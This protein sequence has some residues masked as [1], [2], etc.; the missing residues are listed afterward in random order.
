MVTVYFEVWSRSFYRGWG[1]LTS[2]R[3]S[4]CR[5]S[6]ITLCFNWW[7]NKVHKGPWSQLILRCDL[8]HFLGGGEAWPVRDFSYCRINNITLCFNWRVNKVHKGPWPGSLVTVYFEVWSRTCII[9]THDCV[10]FTIDITAWIN[11][12]IFLQNDI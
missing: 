2:K 6:N 5:I 12:H 1:S 11:Y 3:F 7:V 9:A 4:C 10:S 8:G